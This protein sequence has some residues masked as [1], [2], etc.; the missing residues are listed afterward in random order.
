MML[1]M[2]VMM[3]MMATVIVICICVCTYMSMQVHL[4]KWI[5]R[6]FSMFIKQ[7]FLNVFFLPSGRNVLTFL[8]GRDIREGKLGNIRVWA[9]TYSCSGWTLAQ[10][11]RQVR[12]GLWLMRCKL[13]ALL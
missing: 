4:H 12:A 7:L 9:A 11:G 2:M 1:G 6:K 13:Q 8:V 5:H 3:V 10:L